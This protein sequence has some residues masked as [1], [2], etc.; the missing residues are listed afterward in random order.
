M[1]LTC[2]SDANMGAVAKQLHATALQAE[3][4]IFVAEQQMRAAVNR[5]TVVVTSTAA[6]TGISSGALQD[7]GSTSFASTF[8]NTTGLF[9]SGSGSFGPFNFGGFTTVVGE[10]LYEVGLCVT[11]VASGAV[12]DNSFRQFLIQ[13]NRPDPTA[14]TGAREVQT[15]GILLFEP[16]TGVGVEASFLGHFRVRPGDF[17]SYLFSHTNVGS[18]MNINSGMIMWATK[19]SDSTLTQVL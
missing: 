4:E 10:G 7:L 1:T 5:P 8:D 9:G 17:F 19:V 3:Q 14:I 6:I 12:T 15:T 18:T 16:N 11:A 13:H 2:P